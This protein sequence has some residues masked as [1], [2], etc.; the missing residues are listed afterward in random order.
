[1]KKL[2]LSTLAVLALLLLVA[3]ALPKDFKIEK[4]IVINKPASQVF[5]YLKMTKNENNW[6]P[7]IKKDAKIEQNYK[8]KDGTVGFVVSWSGNREVGAG[9]QEITKITDGKRIDLELRFLKPMKSTNQAYYIIDAVG[10]NQT[11][12]TWGMVGRTPF[13]L[14]LICF[15]M[16][17]QVKGEFDNGLN[18]LKMI[19]EKK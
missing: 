4:D 6:N 5:A 2:L 3:A 18:N 14:N 7:W 19:L 1:M 16:H 11:R 8:G 17:N 13:P 12:V 15:F 9:E 10:K